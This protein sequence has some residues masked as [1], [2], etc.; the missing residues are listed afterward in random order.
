MILLLILECYGQDRKFSICSILFY[1]V[2]NLFDTINQPKILDDAR[3]PAGKYHWTSERYDL[4]L[5][6]I[7]EVI[8]GF[9]Y[10]D[11]RIVPDLLGLCEVENR[12][13]LEDLVNHPLLH[14]HKYGIVH[15]DSPDERG[16]DVAMLYRKSRF[17]PASIQNHGLL[18]YN[19]KNE[20]E[21]TRDQLVVSGYLDSEEVFLIINHWPSRS[22]GQKRTESYRLAA[23]RLT[24]QLADSIRKLNTDP[25]IIIM[26]D[27]NDN[28]TDYSMKHILTAARTSGKNIPQNLFNPMEFL[29]RKGIGSLAYR[30]HWNLFDQII[31]SQNLNSTLR[32]SFRLWQAGVYKP[33]ILIT[34][35]GK[36]KGYPYRTYAGNTYQAGYSDHFPVYLLLIKELK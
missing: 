7:A 8:A 18:L 4:K 13:V 11:K 27:F 30:D 1:N 19:E 3:T 25:K 28:P 21:Y 15:R 29:Y 5:D 36:Y 16:I 31:I 34:P 35:R 26:G 23:A 12:E 9:N 33:E 17:Q 14:T 24:R 22:G 20:R 32:D 10:R 6:R 2:E